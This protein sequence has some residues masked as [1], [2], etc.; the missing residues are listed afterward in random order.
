MKKGIIKSLAVC[1]AL[2]FTTMFSGCS[3]QFT[4][5]CAVVD[6]NGHYVLFEDAKKDW[7]GNTEDAKTI[8]LPDGN[9]M[10]GTS[11]TMYKNKPDKKYY[12]YTSEEFSKHECSADAD[13]RCPQHGHDACEK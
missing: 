1:F 6:I 8:K 3:K 13:W 2:A 7:L 9:E 5:K 10:V 12:E 11:F 4:Y